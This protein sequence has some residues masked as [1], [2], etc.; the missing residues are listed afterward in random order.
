MTTASS[1]RRCLRL[2]TPRGRCSSSRM[3]MLV[4][5]V[6][7]GRHVR[8]LVRRPSRRRRA[9]ER[10]VWGGPALDGTFLVTDAGEILRYDD[11]GAFLGPFELDVDEIPHGQFAFGVMVDRAGN[12]YLQDYQTDRQW[13]V[14]PDGALLAAWGETGNGPASSP[15]PGVSISTPPSAPCTSPTPRDAYRSSTSTSRSPRLPPERGRLMSTKT[16]VAGLALSP[17]GRCRPP[18][19]P[20]R[21]M[22]PRVRRRRL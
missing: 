20:P 10:A 16:A 6:R 1:T 9:V 19:P 7:R 21:S 12:V 5:S 15:C 11:T 4:S 8:A 14:G 17:F 3:P 18:R 2:S 22:T 13:I